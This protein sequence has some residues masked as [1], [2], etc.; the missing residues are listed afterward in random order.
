[1]ANVLFI[2]FLNDAV[3]LCYSINKD[4]YTNMISFVPG[5]S[6]YSPARDHRTHALPHRTRRALFNLPAVRQGAQDRH[7]Y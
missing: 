5:W 1:M 6:Q 4:V 7:F 3:R 2:I